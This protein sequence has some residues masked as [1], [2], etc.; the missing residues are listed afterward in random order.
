MRPD[1]EDLGQ[2][3]RRHH[4]ADG[5]DGDNGAAVHEADRVAVGGGQVQ[6]VEGGDDRDAEP[7]HQLHQSELGMDIE[8]VGGLV[9]DEHPALLGERAGDEDSLLLPSAEGGEESMGELGHLHP[10]QPVGD[11]P[12]ILGRV[13]F[14]HPL[15]RG[16]PHG[17]DFGDAQVELS[18]SLLGN[19]GRSLRRLSGRQAPHVVVVQ[20]HDAHRRTDSPIDRAQD[21]R[22]AAPIGA[23]EP[24]HLSRL[25]D[26]MDVFD[27]G[28]AVD[29]DLNPFQMHAHQA[30]TP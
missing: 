16:P 28:R 9:E 5:A 7:M 13:T 27:D 4:L 23:D 6:V 18:G 15:V 29:S 24:E 30:T 3:L 25:R 19:H 10:R 17:H 11:D 1:A 20:V 21:G 12:C 14:E 26:D 8:V 2:A 22:L